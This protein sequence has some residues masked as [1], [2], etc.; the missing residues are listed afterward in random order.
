[1]KNHIL[2]WPAL[3]ALPDET[4]V[5]VE[6]DDFGKDYGWDDIYTM[7]T[8]GGEKHLRRNA[9]ECEYWTLDAD[10][11]QGVYGCWFRAWALPQ[12]P[13]PEELQDAPEWEV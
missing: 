7:Q 12:A 6:H 10:T 1:M 8:R 5:Y 13:T 4:Q 2:T 9:V 3:L 11:T